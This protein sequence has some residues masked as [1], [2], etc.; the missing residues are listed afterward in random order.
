MAIYQPPKKS[1]T[2]DVL[3]G[4][5]TGLTGVGSTMAGIGGAM[6]LTG[7]G[8]VAG[9]PLAIA[10]AVTAG[11]GALTNV[12][13]SVV[14][15]GQERKAAMY[16]NKYNTIVEGEQNQQQSAENVQNMYKF[17]QSGVSGSVK[18]INEMINPTTSNKGIA[19]NRLI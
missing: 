11:V 15:S 19:S 7:A 10:G 2:G 13:G 14:N 1:N 16:E 17:N 5:G 12:V 3:S 8:A 6:S 18:A 4:I 9:V